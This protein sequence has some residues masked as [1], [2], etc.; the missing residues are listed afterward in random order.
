MYH[1]WLLE[2][3]F[4]PAVMGHSIQYSPV[5]L[6]TTPSLLRLFIGGSPQTPITRCA[7]LPKA[8]IPLLKLLSSLFGSW[9]HHFIH[10]HIKEILNLKAVVFK[11]D[12]VFYGSSPA[13]AEQTKARE[14]R[15]G[16]LASGWG[17]VKQR[18]NPLDEAARTAVL[19]HI[20]LYQQ[21]HYVVLDILARS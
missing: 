10:D 7:R 18:P 3:Q 11:R 1:Q 5:S 13:D 6:S 2:I 9:C 20:V 19:R 16:L 17:S 15:A 4:I 12:A 14:P 21:L 8:G